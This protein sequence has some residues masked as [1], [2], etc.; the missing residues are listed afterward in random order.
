MGSVRSVALILA[1][2]GLGLGLSACGGDE[3]ADSAQ[4]SPSPDLPGGQPGPTAVPT[5][6][7]GDQG[8]GDRGSTCDLLTIAEVEEYV[9]FAAEA[10][11]VFDGADC[12]WAVPGGG[13][14]A[15]DVSGGWVD[16]VLRDYGGGCAGVI[17]S[18]E[19]VSGLGDAA[20]WDWRG[21]AGSLTACAGPDGTAVALDI[22]RS[23]DTT[24]EAAN[25]AS[26]EALMAL[27]LVRL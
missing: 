5:G 8:G 21:T 25:R 12:S 10:Y 15:I 9:D 4:P 19:Q 3:P 16:L 23:G 20:Y 17:S 14:G 27:V 1:V 26:A 7:T 13:G 24:D 22:S 18:G 11:P 6:G 2:V